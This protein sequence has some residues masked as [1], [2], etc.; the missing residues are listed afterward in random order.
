MKVVTDGVQASGGR[1]A[2]LSV[3][4]LRKWVGMDA[5]EMTFRRARGIRADAQVGTGEG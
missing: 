4:F 5:D 3:D 2:G 1:L